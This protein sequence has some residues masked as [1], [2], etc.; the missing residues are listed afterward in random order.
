MCASDRWVERRRLRNGRERRGKVKGERVTAT[1]KEGS[2]DRSKSKGGR[3][4]RFVCASG[5]LARF[6][7]PTGT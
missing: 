2:K 4:R 7:Q 6:P 1:G 3:R 5:L